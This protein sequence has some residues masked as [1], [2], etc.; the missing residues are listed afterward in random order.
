MMSATSG[1]SHLAE[2]SL[3]ALG[4]VHGDSGTSPLS[5]LTEIFGGQH[6]SVPINP[7]NVRGILSTIFCALFS[8]DGVSTT[9][10]S[11]LAAVEGLEVATPALRPFAL[12]IAVLILVALSA[13]QRHDAAA[14]ST[15]FSGRS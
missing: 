3:A 2:L 11:V 14:I 4:V 5:A 7:G 9:A 12:S 13:V 15:F 6:H 8:G 10:I 1:D